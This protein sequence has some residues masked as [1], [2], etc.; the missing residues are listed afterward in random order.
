M[1]S[2]Q[3]VESLLRNIVSVS[4]AASRTLAEAASYFEDEGARDFILESARE[5]EEVARELIGVASEHGLYGVTVDAV[6][7][8]GIRFGSSGQEMTTVVDVTQKVVGLFEH[9]LQ[10]TLPPEVG[11]VVEVFARRA[12]DRLTTMNELPGSSTIKIP[13]GG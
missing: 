5:H 2:H 13:I 3:D 8:G 1:S 10:R 11:E 6:Q 12:N 7:G 4:Q 9:A